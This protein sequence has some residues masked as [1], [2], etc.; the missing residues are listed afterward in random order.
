[1]TKKR[2]MP[3][4]QSFGFWGPAVALVIAAFSWP[5]LA[6]GEASSTAKI[7]DISAYNQCESDTE[8]MPVTLGCPPCA[9][10]NAAA[11]RKYAGKIDFE[12]CTPEELKVRMLVKCAQPPMPRATC[13]NQRCGVV[14]SAADVVPPAIPKPDGDCMVGGCS[15]QLCLDHS[16]G[17]SM[18]TCEW[19][20]E[21]ACYREAKC[22]RQ[23]NGKCGWTPTPALTSCLRSASTSSG[24]QPSENAF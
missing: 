11:H 18:S 13:V 10:W 17:G 8:C 1:M 15:G 5:V 19:R 7:A 9:R 3:L 16:E 20:Q 23:S 14:A 21:Y 4:R 24:A 22:E 6:M 2:Q 12:H